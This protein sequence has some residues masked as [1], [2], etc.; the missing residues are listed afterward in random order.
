[1]RCLQRRKWPILIGQ[2]W[3]T[4]LIDWL[5]DWRFDREKITQFWLVGR[6][7]SAPLC[8]CVSWNLQ[9]AF[10]WI[11]KFPTV[12]SHEI[13]Q[14]LAYDR[15]VNFGISLQC[16]LARSQEFY[17]CSSCCNGT[18]TQVEAPTDGKH[19]RHWSQF[20][21]CHFTFSDAR[22]SGKWKY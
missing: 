20:P 13:E 7:V 8:S 10:S 5:I 17:P 16:L 11:S 22:I 18:N 15:N 19:S 3:R 2:Y 12:I 1:M 6:D 4:F 9:K 14:K 21:L